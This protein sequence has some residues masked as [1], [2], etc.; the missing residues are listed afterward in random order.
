MNTTGRGDFGTLLK[1]QREAAS[2]SQEELAERAGLSV[3][4]VSAL[5]QGLRRSPHLTTV[6][7]LADAL[8]LQGPQRVAFEAASRGQSPVLA[9]AA[10]TLPTL[11]TPLIGRECEEAAIIHLLRQQ[12]VRLLTLTGPGGIG[13]TRLALQVAADMVAQDAFAEDV[14]FVPLAAISD[15]ALV[16]AAIAQSLGIRDV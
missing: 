8:G 13:K 9:P 2:L 15:P 1:R 14:V 6:R 3:Q 16:V 7:H 10:L 12:G 5:E 4:A 11:L